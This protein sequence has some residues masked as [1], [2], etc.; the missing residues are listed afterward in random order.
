M[1]GRHPTLELDEQAVLAGIVALAKHTSSALPSHQIEDDTVA[2]R[3]N[4]YEACQIP[5][6]KDGV[7]AFLE[8]I[9]LVQIKAKSLPTRQTLA[10]SQLQDIVNLINQD[11][12]PHSLQ[13]QQTQLQE[14]MMA[15]IPPTVVG[16]HS[17]YTKLQELE[18]HNLT[19]ITHLK[20]EVND[21][22]AAFAL[23]DKYI[24]LLKAAHT[25][26]KTFVRFMWQRVDNLP[27][28][29]QQHT[30]AVIKGLEDLTRQFVRSVHATADDVR[31]VHTFPAGFFT[32][33]Q[34][35]FNTFMEQCDIRQEVQVANSLHILFSQFEGDWGVPRAAPVAHDSNLPAHA[36]PQALLDPVAMRH[37]RFAEQ[38]DKIKFTLG[39]LLQT[40]HKLDVPPVRLLRSMHRMQA[41]LQLGSE[42][43][44][45]YSLKQWRFDLS[46]LQQKMKE[47][48]AT[49]HMSD[50]LLSRVP[51][52][53]YYNKDFSIPQAA[54]MVTDAS[55]DSFA[56]QASTQ[57]SEVH[58]AKIKFLWLL[59]IA[60]LHMK[61]H[62]C[63]FPSVGAC[64]AISV[65]LLTSDV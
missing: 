1:T 57:P 31:L 48:E 55:A 3:T 8:L 6:S 26:L 41:K 38:L 22:S 17:T 37:S 10:R 61:R 50:P 25:A 64:I 28:G 15:V 27:D 43:L 9:E 54:W 34:Q 21:S 60:W 47:Y 44:S 33:V 2:A 18:Q 30:G 5:V 42:Q 29:L 16:K 14:A 40:A 53:E 13:Q 65:M 11:V 39:E 59:S 62:V 35:Q 7:F 36:A 24:Q 23:L 19:V 52:P 46:Q 56:E 20:N 49:L 51:C 32:N 45:E 12:S 58:V 63:Q 4:I